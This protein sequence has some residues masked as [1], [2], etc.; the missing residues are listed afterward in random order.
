MAQAQ[1][2]YITKANICCGDLPADVV[3]CVDPVK[4]A[5]S[6]NGSQLPAE[7]QEGF[8][9]AQI[10]AKVKTKNSCDGSCSWKYTISYDDV[11]LV[12]DAELF[13]VD[14]LGIFCKDCHIKWIEWL[15]AGQPTSPNT[16][17]RLLGNAGTV[18]GTNFIGTTDDVAFDIRVNN[19]RAR[20]TEPDLL[21][22][23][24]IDGHS[25]NTVNGASGSAIFSGG[26][27]GQANSVSAE[28][29]FSFIGG[30]YSNSIVGHSEQSL[31][32]NGVSNDIDLSYPDST[33]CEFLDYQFNYIGTGTL[34]QI[35]NSSLST[36]LNGYQN[37]I[38]LSVDPNDTTY[39][40]YDNLIL[41][42]QENKIRRLLTDRTNASVTDNT[43]V[44]GFRNELSDTNQATILSGAAN[45]IQVSAAASNGATYSVICT[46]NNNRIFDSVQCFIGSGGLNYIHDDS[47]NSSI[48]N[49][50]NNEIDSA[51][52]L[53]GVHGINTILG[54]YYNKVS[55]GLASSILGGAFLNIGAYSLG[56]QSADEA[57]ENQV[58]P[59]VDVSAFSKIAYFGD[60]DLW[61]ANVG[62]TAKQL[63]LW[64]PNT[65]KSFVTA[66]NSSFEAQTQVAN[67]QYV[68]PAAAG[69]VGQVLKIQSVAGPIVTLEWAN[70]NT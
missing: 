26:T 58:T 52:V 2:C 22:P 12:E 46:G 13:A 31:I 23:R 38:D 55:A 14:V 62:G 5:E 4:A 7:G 35:I 8:V 64:H 48:I 40:A 70:D 30:G 44:S 24:L 27:A 21:S 59:T 34:N 39:C 32:L 45:K 29:L 25:D 36:I 60:I 17:W 69:V 50:Q 43:I 10:T 33:P 63:K 3:L 18:D 57:W 42:G 28:S 20:R 61:V 51:T 65:D 1:L 9:E 54:G 6:N 47:R 53:N 56:Y 19:Q 16:A 41:G 11:Q 67:I 49:G 15:T 66:F 37:V 68:L